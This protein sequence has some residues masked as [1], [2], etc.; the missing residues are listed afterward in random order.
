MD[1]SIVFFVVAFIHCFKE[2]S[3][4]LITGDLSPLF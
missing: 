4:A 3:F 1:L 2:D